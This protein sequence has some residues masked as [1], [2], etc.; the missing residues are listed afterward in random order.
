MR[1]RLYAG[2][3]PHETPDELISSELMTINKPLNSVDTQSSTSS[4]TSSANESNQ[5]EYISPSF[6]AIDC[7]H[8][9]LYQNEN[10]YEYI[11]LD[12]LKLIDLPAEYLLL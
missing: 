12:L 11:E 2:K 6:S 9:M 4:S 8:L 5:L 1:S 3:D 7:D 10:N